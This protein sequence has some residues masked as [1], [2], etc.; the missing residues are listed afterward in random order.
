MEFIILDVVTK[1]KENQLITNFKLINRIPNIGNKE[2]I[3]DIN[4]TFNVKI[5]LTGFNFCYDSANLKIII[6]ESK[7]EL[8]NLNKKQELNDELY[9]LLKQN[10]SNEENCLFQNEG[11]DLIE[12]MKLI[13]KCEIIKEGLMCVG[14]NMMN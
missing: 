7:N 3:N 11:I 13:E 5:N 12:F 14:E 10:I 4:I 9:Q 2:T 1:N 6:G 8:F